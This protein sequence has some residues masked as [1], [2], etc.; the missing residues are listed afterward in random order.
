MKSKIDEF[1]QFI[2]FLEALPAANGEFCQIPFTEANVEYYHCRSVGSDCRT[3]N[4][5]FAKC[6]AGLFH[7]AKAGSKLEPFIAEFPFTT[8]TLPAPGDYLARFYILMF[9]NKEGC[10]EAQ[11]FIS[12]SVNDA[13][14]DNQNLVYKEYTL[15]D[16]E[17]EKKWIQVQV[18]F[19]AS[20]DRVNVKFKK[21]LKFFDC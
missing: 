20:T 11:D 14:N 2:Y 8:I 6:A 7:F 16:L 1:I 21:I 3:T 9:C 4:G 13:N 5:A 12:F 15:K 19:R 17:M 10:E 18:M